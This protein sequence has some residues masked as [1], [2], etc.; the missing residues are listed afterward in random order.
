MVYSIFLKTVAKCKFWYILFNVY[1]ACLQ[2]Y[3]TEMYY[4]TNI[5]LVG[6]LKIND[7]KMLK[8]DIPL[9]DSARHEKL[10]SWC[11]IM[12]FGSLDMSSFEK[13]EVGNAFLTLIFLPICHA[14][15]TFC[16]NL[17]CTGII[18]FSPVKSWPTQQLPQ[19]ELKG[20]KSNCTATKPEPTLPKTYFVRFGKTYT[21]IN[22]PL[23][24][25]RRGPSLLVLSFR[26]VSSRQ[27]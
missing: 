26:S 5:T 27:I 23:V 7:S 25:Y 18:K 19:P 13:N 17:A 22:V 8:F 11:T 9:I 12:V 6:S 10:V 3:N 14:F 16:F 15:R 24:C 21:K 1:H 20:K 2:S 4:L